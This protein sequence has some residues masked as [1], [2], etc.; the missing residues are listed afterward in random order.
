MKKIAL[1]LLIVASL[2]SVTACGTSSKASKKGQSVAKQ[3]VEV[4]DDYLDGIENGKD[5]YEKLERLY[6]QMNYA[7]EYEGIRLTDEEKT[8]RFIHSYLL[9]AQIA[10]SNDKF[11]GDAETYEEVIAERNRLAALVGIKER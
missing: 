3:A 4:L 1:F 5:A 6:D 11:E 9:Y 10:V 7:G 8:D 2:I